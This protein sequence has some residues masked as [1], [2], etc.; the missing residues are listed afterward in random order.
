[1]VMVL[2]H[3]FWIR[4]FGGDSS[5]VGKALKTDAGSVTVIGV[6]QPAPTFPDRMDAMTNMVVSKHHLSAQMV[7][8]RSH[9][10]TEMV[11]RLAPTSTV[12]QAR[13]EVAAVYTRMQ[14]AN[15][16]SYDAGSHFRVSVIPFKEAIGEDARLTLWML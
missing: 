6:L 14:R 10:M 16:E 9:R 11:A 1:A 3:E 13:T 2:T 7:E 4:H 8:V 12:E 5:I 15:K